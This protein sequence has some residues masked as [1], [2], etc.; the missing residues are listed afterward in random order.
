MPQR[1]RPENT[2]PA[3]RPSGKSGF[4]ETRTDVLRQAARGEWE[5]FFQAYVQPCWREVVFACRARGL[6]LEDAD[7]VLQELCLRLMRAGRF[8][9]KS[10]ATEQAAPEFRGNLAARFL[11]HRSLPLASARFRTYL[12]RVLQNIVLEAVRKRR[13]RP[14]QLPEDLEPFVQETVTH[15]VDRA[16]VRECLYVAAA[17][18][19]QYSESARTKGRQRL[20]EVLYRAAVLGQSPGKM[21]VDLGIDRTTASDLLTQAQNKFLEYLRQYARV[22]DESELKHLLSGSAEQIAAA[23]Q[24]AAK[25]P[26]GAQLGRRK[27]RK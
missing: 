14:Q 1:K 17:R 6:P 9:P 8:R 12:K 21:S 18:L 4:P 10:G 22:R 24:Q 15:S 25:L 16:L 3:E 26:H 2:S 11:H 23:L 5:C 27:E 7:E 13:R 19:K 20:F